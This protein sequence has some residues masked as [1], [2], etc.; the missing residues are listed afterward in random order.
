MKEW[1]FPLKGVRK[2]IGLV[3]I[4]HCVKWGS[5]IGLLFGVLLLLLARFTPLL[6]SVQWSIGLF[7]IGG[8]IGFGI[9]LWQR[10][11]WTEV[12][13]QTDQ[14]LQLKE[15]LVTSW[16]MRKEEGAI[17]A[18]QKQDA[19]RKLHERLP[20]LPKKLPFHW[21]KPQEAI[22]WL[23]LFISMI[24]LIWLPNPQTEMAWKQA[25]EEKII[26]KEQEK[27][28]AQI[29]R[30]NQNQKIDAQTKQ[31][32]KQEL[33]HL[34][35]Q[36]D[37]RLTLEQAIEEIAKSEEKLKELE[38]SQQLSKSKQ[39]L[40]RALK[41]NSK[42][43]SLEELVYE[44]E[45]SKRIA[46]KSEE[47]FQELTEAEKKQLSNRLKQADARNQV[48]EK[49]DRNASDAKE[50]FGQMV[51]STSQKLQQQQKNVSSINRSKQTLLKSKDQML[52]GVQPNPSKRQPLAG[53]PPNQIPPD[54]NQTM[55][56]Q[57][58]GKQQGKQSNQNAQNNRNQGNPINNN[59]PGKQPSSNIR[60]YVPPSKITGKEQK[61]V[62]GGPTQEGPEEQQS[63]KLTTERGTT[64]PYNEVFARYQSELREA[65]ER[66]ELPSEWQPL[67]RDYFSS[68][69][70]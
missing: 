6:Y 26:K 15:S 27:I 59:Q 19:L 67:I 25:Q 29:E 52:A 68:I 55:L 2:R 50:S 28:T 60:I 12:I 37:K 42:L 58:Q 69:E 43:A 8:L 46:E 49:I 40:L 14:I 62:V 45:D 66:G 3:R 65:I 10:P 1:T 61:D 32:L 63:K 34:Q 4:W 48:A 51:T 54:Q 31:K 38:Q 22:M 57:R 16:E 39:A 53:D 64:L 7:F 44:S 11:S 35:K 56:S 17:I 70:P 33:H 9:G 30:V 13:Q 41:E 47:A 5:G 36:L 24:T 20:T 18:L 21:G 23:A